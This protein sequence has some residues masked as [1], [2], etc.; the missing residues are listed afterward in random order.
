MPT[1]NSGWLHDDEGARPIGPDPTEEDPEDA[2][3]WA[4]LRALLRADVDRELLAEGGVLCNQ[5]G[6]GDRDR[7]GESE[8]G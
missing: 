8:Q 6:L 2:I 7:A 4:E 3:S 5:P 1:A